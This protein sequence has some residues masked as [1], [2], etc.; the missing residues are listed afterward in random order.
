LSFTLFLLFINN[1][2]DILQSEKLFYADDLAL[3]HMS[4]Y[5]VYS[6]R[7]LNEDLQRIERY[8]EE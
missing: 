6:A 2:P 4:K 8:C 7:K 1:L 3:W 5:P